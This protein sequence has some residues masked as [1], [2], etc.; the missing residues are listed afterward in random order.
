M[1]VTDDSWTLFSDEV[2]LQELMSMADDAARLASRNYYGIDVE[3]I[4]SAIMEIVCKRPDRFER[5][6]EHK[7]WLWS[8]FYSEAILYCNKQVRSFMHFSGE[9]FYT[10]Q[11]VRD[12]L[13]VAY[14]GSVE[15]D[16]MI[17]I[18]EAT[19]SMLDLSR[20][21]NKLNFREQDLIVRKYRCG[22]KFD[23]SDR[24][25]FYRA[26]EHL[27]RVLNRGIEEDSKARVTHEGPGGRR[28]VSNASAQHMTEA[29]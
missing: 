12:L 19:I 20:A 26:T 27:A 24:R 25:A 6:L 1:T 8:V 28:S 2:T 15:L 22:E 14:D 9:Y 11:E 10:P 18:T 5:H 21:F 7:A 29:A 3:D 17:Q 13:K 4:Q 23:S 16:E